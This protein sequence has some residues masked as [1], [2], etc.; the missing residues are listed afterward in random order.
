MRNKVFKEI[1]NQAFHLHA[2]KSLGQNFL[3]DQ[4]VIEKIAYS[5]DSL[6]PKDSNKY[7]H[8]IGPGSGSLTKPLLDREIKILAL[9]K[10][11][12]AVEGLN[13]TLVKNNENNIQV[14]QTDILKF[15]NIAGDC[16]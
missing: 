12:R 1:P 6:F 7:L 8:E 3:N 11:Q 5:I 16:L 4:N 9:E 13:N 2:K 10:D 15:F 14:V